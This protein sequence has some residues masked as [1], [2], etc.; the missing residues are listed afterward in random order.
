MRYCKSLISRGGLI[1]LFAGVGVGQTGCEFHITGTWK[2]ASPGQSSTT[3]YQFFQDGSVKVV[4]PSAP[5][6]G[7]GAR[8]LARA[9]YKL[10]NPTKPKAIEFRPAAKS[11]AF[12]LGNARMEVTKFS[13]TAFTSITSGSDPVEWIKMDSAQYFVILAARHGTPLEGG[14]AFVMLLKTNGARPAIETFGL[15]YGDDGRV[16][17]PVPAEL[18]QQFMAEPKSESDTVLRLSVSKDEFDRSMKIM[19]SWQR[20]AREHAFL[21]P[22]HSYLNSIVPMKE[23]AETIDQ[24]SEKIKLY[25]LNWRVEDE[26]GANNALSEVA[27]LYVKKLRELND[28]LHIQGDRFQQI[29]SGRLEV[30]E[31]QK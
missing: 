19:Q 12:P 14:P 26:I 7:S 9:S 18:Y 17:G 4:A 13:P 5:G 22:D 16:T 21:F 29:V 8:E 15:Y 11:G 2:S 30:V 23:V 3:L 20:R 27:Y 24:C 25:H 28:N 1:L 6:D 10:D 31:P